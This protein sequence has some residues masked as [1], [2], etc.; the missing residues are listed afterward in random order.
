MGKARPFFIFLFD[1]TISWQ[2][3]THVRK[4]LLVLGFEPD[5]SD[6]GSDNSDNCATTMALQIIFCFILYSWLIVNL[7][8]HCIAETS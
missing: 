4:I 3:G 5:L 2:P 1:I 6:V 7:I 8:P